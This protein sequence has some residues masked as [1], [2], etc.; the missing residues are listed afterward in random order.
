M[1]LIVLVMVAVINVV[2]D[3]KTK[4]SN[5]VLQVTYLVKDRDTIS[6]CKVGITLESFAKRCDFG[7]ELFFLIHT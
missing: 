4:E 5:F 7:G 3:M 1:L 6:R 2:N